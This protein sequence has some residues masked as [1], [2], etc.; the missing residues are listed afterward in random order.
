VLSCIERLDA[1]SPDFAALLNEL[2]AAL[3]RIAVLQVLPAAANED[4]DEVLRQLAATAGAEDIQLFYQIAVLGRRDLPWAPDPRLGFE[5]TLLRMLAFRPDSGGGGAAPSTGGGIRTSASRAAA[6][7]AAAASPVTGGA[8][9]EARVA[10]APAATKSVNSAVQAASAAP[11]A[12]PSPTQVREPP[13]SAS[14]TS[15]AAAGDDGWNAR[16]EAIELDPL[17]RQLARHCAWLGQ[18]DGVLRLRLEYGTRHLLTEERRTILERKLATH[19]GA[20]LKLSVEI[21]ADGERVDSPI[22][23]D[24]ERAVERQREA[25]A[26]FDADPTVQDFRRVLGATVRPGSVQPLN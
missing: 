13:P 6:V 18:D 15:A 23:R 7:S 16:I 9:A 17:T 26:A 4:D 1:Q 10:P 3:Q 2:A 14:S 21:A 8:S 12:P 11:S 19:L 24:R 25:E 20:A 5:M 22:Q